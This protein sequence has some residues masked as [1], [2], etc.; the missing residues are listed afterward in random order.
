MLISRNLPASESDVQIARKGSVTMSTKTA[1][2]LLQIIEVKNKRVE[3]AE[4]VVKEKQA[5]L[6]QEMK[7]LAELE[8]E[9]D[10]VKE[11]KIDKLTQLRETM[12]QATTSPKIQQMKVYLKLVDEKLE[13]EEKKVKGQQE[14]V[15]IAEQNLDAA[16]LDL[17]RKRLEVDK[18]LTHKSDWEKEKRKEEQIIEGRE[19]DELGSIIHS[20]QK[21]RM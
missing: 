13:V 6:D 4:K 9:R 15:K 18:L 11:H 17:Q 3:D 10:K 21:R 1:Y 2:P 12:D 16:K 14:Q 8:A 5:A 19:Q 7:K 20:V